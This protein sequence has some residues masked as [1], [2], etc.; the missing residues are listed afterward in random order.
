MAAELL[1]I[2]ASEILEL[3]IYK[4]FFVIVP[5]FEPGIIR[6]LGGGAT[7]AVMR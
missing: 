4:I 1:T 7:V 3:E 6:L 5:E 2:T